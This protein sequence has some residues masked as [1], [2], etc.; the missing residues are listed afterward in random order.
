MQKLQICIGLISPRSHV[1]TPLS[2]SH[3]VPVLNKRL[4]GSLTETGLKQAMDLKSGLFYLE[5]GLCNLYYAYCSPLFSKIGQIGNGLERG[6][7]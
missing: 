7:C 6:F 2:T 1:I 3:V 4:Q 5:N